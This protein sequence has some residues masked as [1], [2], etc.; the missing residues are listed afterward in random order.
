[1]SLSCSAINAGSSGGIGWAN[2]TT[3]NQVARGLL[4]GIWFAKAYGS[5]KATPWYKVTLQGLYIGDTTENGNTFGTAVKANGTLRD[6]KTVGW[7]LDLINY[8]QIYKNLIWDIG[9]GIISPGDAMEFKQ[10][11]C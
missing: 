1:M 8:I 9:L 4:G 7:E 6:D 2:E 5:Y 3:T 10:G 11:R